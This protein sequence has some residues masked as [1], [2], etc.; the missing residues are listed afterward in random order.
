MT[1]N[2]PPHLEGSG[3]GCLRHPLDLPVT[4]GALE[5]GVQVHFVR[6]LDKIGKTLKPDPRDRLLVVPIGQQLLR[7]RGLCSQ[8]AMTG[9]A[10]V[11]GGNRRRGR[12]ICAAMTEEAI[13]LQLSRVALMAECDRLTIPA[14][15][16]GGRLGMKTAP[17]DRRPDY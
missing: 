6:E 9:H 13:N 10:D 15:E 12:N 17:N 7:L 3:A 14:G 2:A 16:V 4:L 11:N 8:G 1:A 5:A